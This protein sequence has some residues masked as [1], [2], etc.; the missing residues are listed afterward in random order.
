MFPAIPGNSE[1]PPPPPLNWPPLPPL[2]AK[3]PFDVFAINAAA[4]K[5]PLDTSPPDPEPPE[6][7]PLLPE[8]P[9]PPAITFN[10]VFVEK[11]SV[12]DKPVPPF[13]NAPPPPICIV[14]VSLPAGRSLDVATKAPPPPPPVWPNPPL[15]PPPIAKICSVDGA[16]QV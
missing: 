15:P 16:L 10:V 9:P 8:F 7:E 5:V 13:T 12:D 14:I 3:Q 11:V 2:F 4:A 1:P 6:V